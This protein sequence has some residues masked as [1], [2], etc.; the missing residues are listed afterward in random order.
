MLNRSRRAGALALAHVLPLVAALSSGC[1][2]VTADLKHSVTA[3]WRKTYELDPGGRVEVANT[4]GRIRVTGASGNRVEIVAEKKARGVSEES[5]KQTLERIEIRET[6]S[7]SSVRVETRMPRMNGPLSGSGEVSY[8]VRVPSDAE[9]KFTTV[10]GGIEITQVNGRIAL[11]TTNGGITGRDVGGPIE[12][13][14]TNGGVD[15]ELTRVAKGGVTL[16]CTN[17]G[18]KLRLPAD[19]QA[20]ITASV[21]NGGIDA[22]G[23]QL[24]KVEST[25]R[26]LEARLNGG[27]PPIKIEGTNGGIR[28]A[29]R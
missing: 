12:A 10:N 25:R 7:G 29:A 15:V 26:S 8:T 28:I 24:E 2:I 27:G 3:D 6:V 18:I 14:T 4:N 23:L 20:T 17:G 21:A 11:E 13:T 16:G 22:D 9:V 1:D 19:A 5:A